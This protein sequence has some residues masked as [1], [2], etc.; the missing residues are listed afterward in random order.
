MGTKLPSTQRGTALLP[1]Y[2]PT[3]LARIA[4]G[5]H[6][7]YNPYYRLG[8]ARRAVLVAILR[9]I[10][11]RL[12]VPAIASCVITMSVTDTYHYSTEI[13]QF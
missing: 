7:T 2:R 1:L 9:I 10:A 5:P 3:A 6:F 11:T 13:V 8:S 4:T 12:V